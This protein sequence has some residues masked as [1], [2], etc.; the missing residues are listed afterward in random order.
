VARSSFARESRTKRPRYAQRETPKSSTSTVHQDFQAPPDLKV[1]IL[2]RIVTFFR[3]GLVSSG[4]PVKRTA[5]VMHGG[6]VQFGL[7]GLAPHDI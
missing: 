1:D 6:P 2:P 5:K 3:I 7:L 4:Q